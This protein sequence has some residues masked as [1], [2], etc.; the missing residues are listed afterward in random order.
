M[1]SLKLFSNAPTTPASRINTSHEIKRY[2][3]SQLAAAGAFEI[4]PQTALPP[5]PVECFFQTQSWTPKH[6]RRKQSTPRKSKK[7]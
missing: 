3:P 6:G 7:K 1:R 4:S 5:L 2:L